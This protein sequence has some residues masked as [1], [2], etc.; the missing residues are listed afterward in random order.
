MWTSLAARTAGILAPGITKCF[1][2][3]EGITVQAKAVASAAHS[4]DRKSGR[5]AGLAG[6]S[7]QVAL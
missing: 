2:V 7:G 5:V 4:G 3:L 6:V 1:S